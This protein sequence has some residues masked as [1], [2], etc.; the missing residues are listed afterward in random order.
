[1]SPFWQLP[2]P[3][4][5]G[6]DGLIDDIAIDHMADRVRR[7][8]AWTRDLHRVDERPHPASMGDQAVFESAHGARCEIRIENQ[9]TALHLMGTVDGM[10]ASTTL[11]FPS[12]AVPSASID[13]TVPDAILDRWDESLGRA[14]HRLLRNLGDVFDDLHRPYRDA[15]TDVST[16]L[17]TIITDPARDMA[18]RLHAPFPGRQAEI[19]ASNGRPILRKAVERLIV[20]GIPTT[21]RISASVPDH[22]T[23]NRVEF[24]VSHLQVRPS[25]AVETLRRLSDRGLSHVTDAFP[26]STLRDIA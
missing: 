7:M 6:R 9:D 21:T 19:V 15:M 5:V 24:S 20:E 1:M 23:M 26:P 17:Q 13:A 22:M 25:S 16:L 18:V 10:T 12:D 2:A 11:R 3:Q 4:V 8:R 14:R